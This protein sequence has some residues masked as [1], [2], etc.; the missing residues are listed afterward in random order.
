MECL[1]NLY[2]PSLCVGAQA[3][4]NTLQ[5]VLATPAAFSTLQQ[6]QVG[7]NHLQQALGVYIGS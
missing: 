7:F 5:H 4:N 2:I 6:A 1:N 3:I